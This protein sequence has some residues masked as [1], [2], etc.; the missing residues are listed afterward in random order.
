VGKGEISGRGWEDGTWEGR[1]VGRGGGAWRDGEWMVVVKG[2]SRV[3][4]VKCGGEGVLV[5]KE[6]GDG[7]HTILTAVLELFANALSAF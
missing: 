2:D 1:C 6:L 5:M 3:R 4:R 7:G